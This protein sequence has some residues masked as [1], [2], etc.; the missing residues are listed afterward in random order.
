MSDDEQPKKIP[1]ASVLRLP[2]G[3]NALADH[4][5]QRAILC[6]T[7]AEN[8]QLLDALDQQIAELTQLRTQVRERTEMRGDLLYKRTLERYNRAHGQNP[9]ITLKQV[10]EEMGVSYE[11]VRQYRF[12]ERKRNSKK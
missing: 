10:C 4:I 6:H 7:L 5:L 11:S 3:G 9:K 1:G 2:L 12:R 8:E